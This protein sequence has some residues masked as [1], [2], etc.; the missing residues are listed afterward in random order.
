M[1]VKMLKKGI[2]MILTV[3]PFVNTES[4][5]FAVANKLG[6]LLRQERSELTNELLETPALT[7]FQVTPLY[8]N[9]APEGPPF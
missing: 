5:N 3:T 6:L 4:P 9:T 8:T 2:R 1:M 7:S